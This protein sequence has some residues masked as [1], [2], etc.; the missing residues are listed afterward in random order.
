MRNPDAS[1]EAANRIR[2]TRREVFNAGSYYIGERSRATGRIFRRPDL[3]ERMLFWQA[4][5][6]KQGLNCGH[7]HARF[8]VI[9]AHGTVVATMDHKIKTVPC[10]GSKSPAAFRRPDLSRG[11]TNNGTVADRNR[12]VPSHRRT[13]RTH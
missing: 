13:R 12:A 6:K 2:H 1:V 9:D 11:F 8:F 7:K 3:G 10:E 5:G 4:Y